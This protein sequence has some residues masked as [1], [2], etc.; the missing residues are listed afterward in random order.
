MIV[1]TPAVLGVLYACVLF[2]F[3]FAPVQCKACFTWEDALEICSL[4]LLSLYFSVVH[5]RM[6]LST[7]HL[8]AL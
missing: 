1:W 5:G 2:F 3:L 4:L 7:P 6:R 8:P